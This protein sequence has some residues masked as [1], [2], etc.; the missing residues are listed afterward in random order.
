[1]FLKIVLKKI[2]HKK[3]S[4]LLC[5]VLMG[6]GVAIISLVANL[7]KQLEKSFSENISGIDMVVG[8]KG[9]PLQLILSSV[10]HIDAPTGNISL[11]EANRIVRSNPQV[12]SFIPLSF[13]DNF[14]GYRIVGSTPALLEKYQAVFQQG[15]IFEEPMQVVL[16]AKVAEDLELKLDNTFQSAHGLDAEGETH[17][18]K[19]YNVSG[20]LQPTGSVIDK[21]IL[22][23]LSSIWN[24]H[25]HED[26]VHEE[27]REITAALVNFRSPMGLMTMPRIINENSTMQAALPSIEMNRL[28]SLF[29]SAI[30]ISKYLA[31][32]IVVISGLSVFISLYNSLKEEQEEKALM[33][34]LGASRTTVFGLL[35][36]EGLLLSALGYILGL[37]I[38][39]LVMWLINQFFAK[40]YLMNL[41]LW[42]IS[43]YEI[44]LLAM[45]LVI[46]IISAGLPSIGVY[47]INLSETLA[48][49]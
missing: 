45:A 39:R 48:K 42:E 11:E 8:A 10:F 16:G 35:L 20:I 19:P 40:E 6:I 12:K 41:N 13:G 2:W 47:R 22:C 28:L 21:L 7:G 9:S 23:D 5:I 32:L 4:S 33:M 34:T 25:I 17:E 38:S 36:T 3:L 1:M 46:G 29:G 31:Y 30:D 44:Y 27:D 14:K 18:Q 43:T 37:V 24:I 49:H 15:Q 26:E